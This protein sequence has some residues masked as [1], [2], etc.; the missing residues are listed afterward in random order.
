MLEQ[1]KGFTAYFM[2]NEFSE[3]DVAKNK[4]ERQDDWRWKDSQ[5]KELKEEED[6]A[7]AEHTRAMEELAEKKRSIMGMN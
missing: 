4:G 3:C 2:E 5:L 6:R 7:K 1:L